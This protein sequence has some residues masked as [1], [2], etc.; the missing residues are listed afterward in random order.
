MGRRLVPVAEPSDV[1]GPAGRPDMSVFRFMRQ[2]AEQEP[3]T[4]YGDGKQERDFTYVD[5][6]ARGTIAALKPLGFEVINLGG[7][8]PVRLD[9]VIERIAELFGRTPTVHYRPA[10]PADVRATWANVEKARGQLDWIPQV[11]IEEGLRRTADWYRANRAEIL[12]LE[13][14]K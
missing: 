11:G 12:P 4:V 2:I 13:F 14:G 9:Y 7:N 10:D 1:Y 3:I 6:L 5:D 8:R